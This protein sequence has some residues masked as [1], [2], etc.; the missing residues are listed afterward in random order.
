MEN[1][2]QSDVARKMDK[3]GMRTFSLLS[4]FV[5][6]SAL[7]YCYSTTHFFEMGTV[8]G[9]MILL[10]ILIFGMYYSKDKH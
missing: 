10:A 5:Y 9:V 7:G 1:T 8:G 3:Q 2:N 4:L 6:F